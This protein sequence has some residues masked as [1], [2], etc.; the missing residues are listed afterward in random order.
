MQDRS[1]IVLESV[2]QAAEHWLRQDD[3]FA[4]T[5]RRIDPDDPIEPNKAL[6]ETHAILTV[7]RGTD[8]G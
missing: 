3:V 4:V 6:V 5:I 1:Y 2:G 8:D 7:D